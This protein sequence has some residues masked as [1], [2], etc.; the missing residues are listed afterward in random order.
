ML[1]TEAE[2][3]SATRTGSATTAAQAG[4][5]SDIAESDKPGS[6]F[7]QVFKQDKQV[8]GL[9]YDLVNTADQAAK[10]LCC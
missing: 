3:G 1:N 4:N 6:G 8:T 9:R 10:T 2:D 7:K 5:S